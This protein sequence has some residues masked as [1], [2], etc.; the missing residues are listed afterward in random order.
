MSKDL[1]LTPLLNEKTYDL[2][3]SRNVFVFKVPKKSSKQLIASGVKAQFSVDVLS[4]N[5]ATIKGKA[6]RT[7]SI[8]GKR[9]VNSSGNRPDFK[10]AYVTLKEGQSLPFFESIEE[11]EAKRESNQEKFDTAARKQA[12]KETKTTAKVNTTAKHRFL[13]TKKPEGN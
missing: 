6:K 1:F 9:S 13:R 12:E 10:K 2:S 11:E 7:M 8:T 5:T 4:V 3:K